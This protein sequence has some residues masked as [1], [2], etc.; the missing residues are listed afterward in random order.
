MKTGRIN[1]VFDIQSLEDRDIIPSRKVSGC[2]VLS[3]V[4]NSKKADVPP[5][6]PRS[7]LSNNWRFESPPPHTHTRQKKAL[8]LNV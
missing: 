6:N 5:T 4:G 1:I 8:F 2:S 7:I 3:S